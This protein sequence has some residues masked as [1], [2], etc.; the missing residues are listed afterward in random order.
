MEETA[1]L[2]NLP[3]FIFANPASGSCRASEYIELQAPYLQL[4]LPDAIFEVR[5]HDLQNLENKASGFKDLAIMSQGPLEQKIRVIA[6]GGD[7]TFVWV[8]EECLKAQA[9]ISKILF[10]LMPFGTGNDLAASMGWG[11]D[12][13][14]R[15]IGQH[16]K[17]LKRSL[18][19]W[20]NAEI[21]N[22]D[23]WNITINTGPSGGI[24]KIR[25]LAKGFERAQ[26]LNDQGEKS[27]HT[28]LMSNYF[29]IGVDARI[30]LGFDKRRSKSKTWNKCIYVW[31]GLKKMCCM[32]THHV[33]EVITE[34]TEAGDTKIFTSEDLDL[35]NPAVFVALN[36][37]TYGGGDHRIW[38][39]ATPSKH[40]NAKFGATT[41][42]DQSTGDGL[43]EFLVFPYSICLAL[44]QTRATDGQGRRLYQ[45]QGPFKLDL[46]KPHAHKK[47]RVY[48]EIDGEYFYLTSPESVTIS[49]ADV[50][51]ERRLQ[52]LTKSMGH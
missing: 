29:S 51:R 21:S 20:K 48:M 44:E 49:L 33:Q 17:G 5:I 28:R 40:Y 14:R 13:P 52:I 45:G 35:S 15:I 32:S 18:K 34:M 46:R 2:P 11:R 36:V 16:M 31:E 42:K 3:V 4:F 24:F 50:S 47:E 22:F 9:D 6:C 43:L 30:G 38:E 25:K 10:C 1:R 41:L 23:L 27:S 19:H 12:P 26:I 7:G 39:R 37:R 8:I